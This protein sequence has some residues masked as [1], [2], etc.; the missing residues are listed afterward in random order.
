MHQTLPAIYRLGDEWYLVSDELR[1]RK[2]SEEGAEDRMRGMAW[3]CH[4][5]MA[6]DL[7]DEPIMVKPKRKRGGY[8]DHPISR[9]FYE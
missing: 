7:G 4:G 2:V 8:A 3:R 5:A 1:I 6:V 9:G